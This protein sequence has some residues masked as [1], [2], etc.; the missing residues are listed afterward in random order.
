LEEPESKT[1]RSRRQET[2]LTEGIQNTRSR[3]RTKKG[4][5]HR[6]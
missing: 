3:A 4:R 1:E 5:K 6:H 2:L